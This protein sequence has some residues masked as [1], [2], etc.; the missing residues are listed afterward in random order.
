MSPEAIRKNLSE[1]REAREVFFELPVVLGD[2]VLTAA[3]SRSLASQAT[4]QERQALIA[5]RSL[6]DSFAAHDIV[7]KITK[8]VQQSFYTW[9]GGT[10]QG[11]A[12]Y[13]VVEVKHV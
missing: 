11:S 8:R 9:I 7:D 12:D 13:T 3:V 1:I 4:S 10:D 5:A 2:L 6:N